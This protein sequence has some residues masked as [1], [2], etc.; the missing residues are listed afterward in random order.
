MY[1]YKLLI[2]RQINSKNETRI[3]SSRNLLTLNR[4]YK[5]ILENEKDVVVQMAIYDYVK[6]KYVKY[7]DK[8]DEDEE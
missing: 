3:C 5:Y 8:Y 1:R 4:K 6:M 7:Y 2:T